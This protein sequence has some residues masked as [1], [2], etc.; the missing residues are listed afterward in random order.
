[1]RLARRTDPTSSHGAI[2][3]LFDTGAQGRQQIA[4]SHLVQSNPGQSYL[5]LY[6][7]HAAESQKPGGELVFKDPPAL[8]RRL[9]EVATRGA[10]AYCRIAD[11]KVLTW[12]PK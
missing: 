9:N 11:R 2:R 6:E 5:R 10:L 7:I 1:M 8:M 4:A 3:D 12:W